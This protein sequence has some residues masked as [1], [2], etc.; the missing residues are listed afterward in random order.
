MILSQAQVLNKL[1]SFLIHYRRSS[2]AKDIP[3][4]QS[5]SVICVIPWGTANPISRNQ[6]HQ[7]SSA[8]SFSPFAITRLFKLRSAHPPFYPNVP[9]SRRFLR[10]TPQ[11]RQ[12]LRCT[13]EVRQEIY[14]TRCSCGT[15]SR[16]RLWLALASVFLC[17]LCGEGF[18]LALQFRFWQWRQFWQSLLA[19]ADC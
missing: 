11:V 18:G 1:T 16:P 4:R 5:S 15:A 10:C 17:G 9:I 8:G 14:P 3:D 12:Y 2:A 7:R 13:A 6:S 19:D